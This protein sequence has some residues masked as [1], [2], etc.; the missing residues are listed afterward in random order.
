MGMMISDSV[1]GLIPARGGSRGI[2]L[3]SLRLLGGVPLIAHTIRAALASDRLT[4]VIVSTDHEG[5]AD[6]AAREGAEVPFLRPASLAQD[7]TADYPVVRHAIDWLE[8]T[9]QRVPEILALLRPTTP[10]KSASSINAAVELLSRTGAEAVRSVTRVEGVHH[11]YWMYRL[12]D[13]DRATTFVQGIDVERDYYRRQLLP[14]VF[15]LN[16]VVDALNVPR[17]VARGTMYGSDIR[18]LPVD[19]E[20]ALDI[21]TEIDL[22]V[23]EAMLGS[24]G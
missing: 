7:D 20:E 2:P 6:V 21:D 13:G 5:I 24:R 14:P 16:G 10:F 17:M 1:L 8:S 3:K 18:G 15:R 4:R 19:E 22:L 12:G 23:C 9:Q 11:P